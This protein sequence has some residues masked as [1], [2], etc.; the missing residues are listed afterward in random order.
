MPRKFRILGQYG[1]YQYVSYSNSGLKPQDQG[2]AF[3]Q[4]LGYRMPVF[5]IRVSAQKRNAYT[6]V[7]Q[8]E[9]AIQFFQ[10]GFFNPQ[11]TDQALCAAGA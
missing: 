9:L 11:M 2:V 7:A 5:D 6:K 3:E 4:N 10:L 8:N 1:I